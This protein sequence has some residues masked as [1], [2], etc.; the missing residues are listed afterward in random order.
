MRPSLGNGW[1][2]GVLLLQDP[3]LSATTEDACLSVQLTG[4]PRIYPSTSSQLTDTTALAITKDSPYGIICKGTFVQEW[5]Y[6]CF[7]ER[8]ET[9]APGYSLELDIFANVAENEDVRM[10]WYTTP[11]KGRRSLKAPRAATPLK[12]IDETTTTTLNPPI[13]SPVSLLD[14]PVA[15]TWMCGCQDGLKPCLSSEP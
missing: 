4:L 9:P 14:L 10:F 12:T 13:I 11:N 3:A 2:Y 1:L 7:Y 5:T 8:T 6:Q 15:K